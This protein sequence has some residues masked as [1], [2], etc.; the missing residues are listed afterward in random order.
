MQ[1]KIR[2]AAKVL[3]GTFYHVPITSWPTEE[4]PR[5]KLLRSGAAHLTDAEL[6]AILIRTGKKGVTAVD[7]ARHLFTDKRTLRDVSAMSVD[8]I[9][10]QGIGESRAIALV[11]AFELAKRLPGIRQKERA[12]IHSPED[13]AHYSGMMLR[14][15]VQ[16]ELWVFP[17]N[18]INQ[19]LEPKQ[20][21]KGILNSSL[22]HPRECFRE[23]IAQ[24]AAAVIFVHNH[25]SGNLE[26]S[27]EDLAIT[28][29]L[30]EAG[31]IIGIEVHD[32]I[33]VGGDGYT[34]FAQ[35]KLLI[36]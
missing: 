16:E 35:R 27:Q 1:K 7:L 21:S 34:S 17:L 13:I 5:E 6:I 20:I 30:V 22:A 4:R 12:T 11:A 19:L 9:R 3:Q 24:S 15:L 18:S 25:P 2:E 36:S 29:Q 28:K 10:S 14:D 33:I 26:P 8:E 31:R 32:H 23:A